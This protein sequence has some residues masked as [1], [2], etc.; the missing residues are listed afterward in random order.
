MI[1][2][3][4]FVPALCMAVVMSLALTSGVE[5]GTRKKSVKMN[6]AQLSKAISQS[7]RTKAI[8][9]GRGVLGT[10][11]PGATK[12]EIPML[13]TIEQV[14]AFMKDCDDA[15]GGLSSEPHPDGKNIVMVCDAT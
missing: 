4:G 10:K 3:N 8:R 5:A 11:Q 13:T 7:K 9:R 15:G 2:K 6:K 12:E 14:L 1:F